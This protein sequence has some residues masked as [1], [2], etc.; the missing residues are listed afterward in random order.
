M[1]VQLDGA[2]NFGAYEAN[3]CSKIEKIMAPKLTTFRTE[4]FTSNK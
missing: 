4:A 1:G 2:E 3:S